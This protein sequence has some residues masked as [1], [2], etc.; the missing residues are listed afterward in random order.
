[1]SGYIE[2]S[3]IASCLASKFL[4]P[5]HVSLLSSNHYSA[6]LIKST[7]DAHLENKK[8]ICV[9]SFMFDRDF[10][11]GNIIKQENLFYLKKEQKKED[12]RIKKTICRQRNNFFLS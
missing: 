5:I 3:R 1:L 9:V 12:D 10:F 4:S 6:F 2:Y 8:E 7:Y 11:F